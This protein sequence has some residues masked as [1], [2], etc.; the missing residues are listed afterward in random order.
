MLHST[1]ILTLILASWSFAQDAGALRGRVMDGDFGVPLADV[2]IVVSEL[3]RT[4][5]SG[6]DGNW[7]LNDV[8]PGVYTVVVSK[9]GFI[10]RIRGDVV[11]R[12]GTPS[13]VNFELMGQ[14]D[15]Q[16]EFVVEKVE[17]VGGTELGLLELRAESPALLDSISSELI[18]R[19]EAGDAGAALKLRS[20]LHSNAD[21]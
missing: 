9:A 7:A 6:S 8:P 18:S 20:K 11:V 19:A 13:D 5:Q 16:E 15:D 12:S 4:T 14:F 1:H 2:S 10:Q 21:N 3:Q 17:T